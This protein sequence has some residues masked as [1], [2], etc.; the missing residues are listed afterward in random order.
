MI[1]A[2][3]DPESPYPVPVVRGGV[4]IPALSPAWTFIT[5]LIDTGAATSCVHPTDALALGGMTLSMLKRPPA[6]FQVHTR[7]GIGGPARYF[8]LPATYAFVHHDDRI[9]YIMNSSV[10]IAQW[11]PDNEYLPSLLG[12][13]VLGHFTLVTN[14]PE[15][16]VELHAL[17]TA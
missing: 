16:R 5:F 7:Q 1:R 9:Q 3:F 12:W 6:R 14:W 2:S 10:N 4:L 17:S 11:R 13:D 15:R 8:V